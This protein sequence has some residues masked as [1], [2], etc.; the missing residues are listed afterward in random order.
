MHLAGLGTN[1]LVQKGGKMNSK[2][3]IIHDIYLIE[4]G[5]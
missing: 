3:L 2:Q 4:K 1:E 5:A